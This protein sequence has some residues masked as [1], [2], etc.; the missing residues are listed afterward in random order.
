MASKP[1]VMSVRR[2]KMPVRVQSVMSGSADTVA[3]E[4]TV[5][6]PHKVVNYHV[7]CSGVPVRM[8]SDRGVFH[9]PKGKQTKI[10]WIIEGPNDAYMKVVVTRDG[11]TVD[12]VERSGGPYDYFLLTQS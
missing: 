1:G 6:N 5:S 8:V 11:R 2:R 12:E 10:W 3:L 9:I 7:V 4:I